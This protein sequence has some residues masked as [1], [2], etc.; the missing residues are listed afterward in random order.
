MPEA[1]RF[2]SNQPV[3]FTAD[4]VEYDRDRG[5]VTARGRVEAWQGER[6][7]RA[8]EFTYDRNTE[9]AILR[10]N[11]QLLEADGQV[12]FAD[13][14]ELG[15]GFRDGV[16]SGVRALMAQNARMAANGARRTGGEITDLSRVVYSSCN[17]CANDP[18]RPPL[19]QMRAR[20]AT[21]DRTT[22][23]I[24][25]RGATLQIGGVPVFYT[26]FFSHPDP[27]TPR[28][29]GF[30]FP[31]L[32]YTRFLG[33]FAQTPYF[34][35]IDQSQDLLITPLFS[36]KELPNLGLEYRRLFNNGELQVQGSI[37]YFRDQTLGSDRQVAGHIF[38]RGRFALD[39]NWRVG[40]DANR[41]S[42][43]QYLRT[44]RFEHRRVLTSRAFAEG[45][46]GTEG[47]ALLEAR[48][49]QGLRVNDNLSQTPYVTPNLFYE[50]APRQRVLGGWLTTD[51]GAL[52]LVR[53]V[54]AFSQRQAVRIAWERPMQDG[55]GGLWTVRAQSDLRNY[56]AGGQERLT[57]P[58]PSA[59]GTHADAN[60]RFAVDWRM[61]FIRQGWGTQVVEPRVQVVTGPN[62]GR[63]TRFPNEDSID[64]E[65]NDANLFALN[66]FTGRDRQEGGTRVDMA[67]RGGW[68]MP[69]G[70]QLE[71]VAG[72]S[73]RMS[74]E[75]IF[76]A[77]TGL[78]RR[79]SDWVGRATIA[80]T[81]WLNV[82]GR[83]RLDGETGRHR[84]TDAVA[85]LSLGSFGPFEGVSVNAGYL[86]SPP[87]PFFNPSRTRNEVSAGMSGAWRSQAGGVWRAAVNARYDLELERPVLITSSFGYEDE[88]F[89]LEG[90][91]LRRFAQD[92]VTRQEFVGNTVFLVRLGFKTVG[93]YFFRAI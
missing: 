68:S 3:T 10:G 93:D 60:I 43:E 79:W 87:L 82:T 64:F 56:F 47:Y 71:G 92:P 25:Y 14:A 27:Q 63:Q 15:P 37:G 35:A 1:S 76:P 67:L 52:G 33:A 42:S 28:A 84:A 55:L 77:N 11:V 66:R 19:W 91:F 80:P 5:V 41:A 62:T 44:Y 83:T 61:P 21:Q 70:V 72:R 34:W 8:D 75:A 81:P 48:A 51:V 39:E 16:L 88:C 73:V 4:E 17:L 7:L 38:A 89:I 13:E 20:V 90:R 40:L 30:L 57:N 29:S 49:Y 12:F 24:S 59:N 18:S 65:F 58:L 6:V 74:N 53:G 85:T 50:R 32:G 22:E 54:G 45:F 36:S 46:W 78:D 23:R 69:N 26:P 31:T 86:Y 9:V 2:D